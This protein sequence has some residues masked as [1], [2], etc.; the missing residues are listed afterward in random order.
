MLSNLKWM[1]LLFF[2]LFGTQAGYN[3]PS[4]S[5]GNGNNNDKG[6]VSPANPSASESWSPEPDRWYREPD[7]VIKY[8]DGN[9]RG[10]PWQPKDRWYGNGKFPDKK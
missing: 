1:F 10:P 4:A 8:D 5:S 7:H 6:R 2:F 9:S 3:M